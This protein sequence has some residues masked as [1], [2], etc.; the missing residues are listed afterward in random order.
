MKAISSIARVLFILSL[1]FLFFSAS[2]A[3]AVNSAWLYTSGFEKQN[4]GVTTGLDK[5]ELEKTARGLI[6]YW[7][8]GDEFISLNVTR[9]GQPF[10]L[11][12]EKEKDHL[13][14][15]K[16]LFRLDYK[17]LFVTG[18][19]ALAYVL[20]YLFQRKKLGLRHLAWDVAGGSGLT[21]ILMLALG[22]GAL[23]GANE[24]ANFWYRFHV[25]SFANDLW[26][27]DPTKD[28]LLMLVPEGFWYDAV[29]DIVFATAGMALVFGGAAA[30]HLVFNRNLKS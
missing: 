2:I 27:L 6:G 22:L 29:R 5:A 20:I 25:L 21:L 18:I 3:W 19:Y 16:A 30:A 7:N 14:D 28:Y 12:N 26:L 11:F 17:V 8:S 10:Q 1:S 23:V 15:V 9:D 13:R 24:F 4:V